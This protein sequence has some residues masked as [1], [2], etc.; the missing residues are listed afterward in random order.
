MM[1]DLNKS[2]DEISDEIDAKYGI[3]PDR[4]EIIKYD[5]NKVKSLKYRKFNSK[6]LKNIGIAV[7]ILATGTLIFVNTFK[8]YLNSKEK[9]LL[10]I[11]KEAEIHGGNK[12]YFDDE[13]SGILNNHIES[14]DCLIQGSG[15]VEERLE[16]LCKKEGFS[17]SVIDAVI[18]KFQLNYN[19]EY[20]EANK[21]NPLKI[22]QD[23]QKELK[24]ENDYS[25][26][27]YK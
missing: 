11:V 25:Y 12:S 21:I 2:I 26:N 24:K 8:P 27:T 18:T 6:N 23:E 13:Y 17:D 1:S 7:V 16:N 10:Q 9:I 20:K 3:A 14:G 15:L 19:N 4:Q 5:F 22:Y